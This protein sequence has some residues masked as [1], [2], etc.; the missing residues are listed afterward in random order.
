MTMSWFA[1]STRF[2]GLLIAAAIALS[3]PYALAVLARSG[4]FCA[5]LAKAGAL[6]T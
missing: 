2:A 4:L 3:A 5:M 1:R 6:L